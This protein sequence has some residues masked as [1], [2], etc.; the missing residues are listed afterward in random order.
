[1][2]VSKLPF[3][4]HRAMMT[5]RDA[6]D[7]RRNGAVYSYMLRLLLAEKE[8]NTTSIGLARALLQFPALIYLDLSYT[9]SAKDRMVL[10]AISELHELQVLKLRGIGLKDDDAEFLANGVGRRV[11]FLDLRNNM[12]T[13]MAVRSL[14]QGC[15]RAP[16]IV[17]SE[18]NGERASAVQSGAASCSMSSN[19]TLFLQHSNIDD[20]F[21]EL[22]T[23]PLTGR[24]LLENLPH[25]GI[26]H[27]LIAE[28]QLTVEGVAGLL[29][30]RLYMLDAG[31]VDTVKSLIKG[32]PSMP[33]QRYP[34]S[35]PAFP[36]VEKLIPIIGSAAKDGL[37]YLRIHHAVVT[38]EPPIRDMIS[39]V[40][41]IAELSGQEQVS[42]LDTSEQ[43]VE[44]DANKQ[45]LELPAETSRFELADTSISNCST[46]LGAHHLSPVDEDE[47]LTLRRGS[48]FAPETVETHQAVDDEH[49]APCGEEEELP[50]EGRP[51]T[52][53]PR[54]CD[55]ST[56]PERALEGYSPHLDTDP[57]SQKIKGL[58]GKRPRNTTF[59]SQS[60]GI[61]GI[62]YL[63]PCHIPHI[64]TL[65]LTDVP[66][67]VP[68]DSPITSSLIH[69]IVA[70]SDESL[71]A[72]L[73]AKADYSLPPGRAR[74]AAEQQ[75]ARALFGL[76]RLV[77]EISP[78]TKRSEL[79]KLS[80]W[81]PRSRE[82]AV[83]KSAT[84]DLDSERL[85]S[86]ALA[87]FSFFGEEEC[88]IPENDTGKYFSTEILNEKITLVPED[89]EDFGTLELNSQM[90]P[91]FLQPSPLIGPHQHQSQPNSPH[92]RPTSHQGSQSLS[93]RGTRFPGDNVDPMR[94]PEI[95]LVSE[96]ASF[97]RSKKREYEGLVKNS[98][99]PPATFLSPLISPRSSWPYTSFQTPSSSSPLSRVTRTTI[100]S[101]MPLHVEGHWKGEVKI[102]RNASPKGRSGV[103]DI[104]GNY[105]EK[106][107]L[108]P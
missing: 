35:S 53:S 31:T 63:H 43:R 70:C 84:G 101:I 40:D 37:T 69:F 39:P 65:I 30:S 78:T 50:D 98:R 49:T 9:T 59:S 34:D 97:R 56:Y 91:N 105:F 81:R 103:V 102:V 13:D 45:I 28:N 4:D 95:D 55:D 51:T 25:I 106:G 83:S 100:S 15:F 88:G 17:I 104:Y 90:S 38:K 42:Q 11:R 44:L 8:P 52:S 89:D 7:D 6:S 33:P 20:K 5:L 62:P 22:L 19:A 14:M 41:K 66:S 73:K 1:L 12:L 67:H 61:V 96:L 99:E 85:W 93:P 46:T 24:S 79:R 80:P 16:E 86:A 75:H 21:V 32:Q 3:F 77:L 92:L 68:V 36:G 107:Y 18:T 72:S 76:R 82:N 58:L 54:P 87:D 71:L 23:R 29:S 47:P 108:Y 27:L 74:I 60:K 57:R 26:T 64:E 10:S 2:I 94:E 48:A